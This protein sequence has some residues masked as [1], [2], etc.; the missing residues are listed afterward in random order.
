MH[1]DYIDKM[2]VIIIISL[3]PQDQSVRWELL[4]LFCRARDVPLCAFLG[5]E[6][7]ENERHVFWNQCKL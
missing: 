3:I 6:M 2:A 1:S 7:T 4:I 5:L